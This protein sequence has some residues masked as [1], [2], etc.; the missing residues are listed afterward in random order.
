[1]AAQTNTITNTITMYQSP[2]YW[3]EKRK[4]K[5]IWNKFGTHVLRIELRKGPRP[6]KPVYYFAKEKGERIDIVAL[7]DQ[8]IN[9]EIEVAYFIELFK[10]SRSYVNDETIQIM[11]LIFSKYHSMRNRFK[12]KYFKDMAKYVQKPEVDRG[13]NKGL[14]K[15]V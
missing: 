5:K 12:K 10:K 15:D 9:K 8:I 2:E 11:K 13:Q 3:K 6:D 1:M 14:Q 7:Y 4:E